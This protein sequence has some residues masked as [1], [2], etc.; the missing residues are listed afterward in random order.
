MSLMRLRREAR[1]HLWTPRRPNPF[2]VT[3]L[4]LLVGMMLTHLVTTLS[5]I[6]RFQQEIVN[7]SFASMDLLLRTG[8]ASVLELPELS[9][10]LLGTFFFIVPWIFIWIVELGYLFYARGIVKGDALGY[11]S[12]MEGFN[13]FFKAVIL[14][15]IRAVLVFI[16]LFSFLIPGI[17]IICALSQASLLLLDHPDKGA[18]WCLRESARIMRGRKMEYFLLMLSFFGWYILTMLPLINIA[19]R[20]WYLPYTTLTY[21]GYYNKITGQ[22]P[23]EPQWRRPG[24]F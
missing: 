15:A 9:P 3:M 24:M 2:L 5:E 21:V 23:E 11:W 22:G 1:A 7:N 10:T 18:L 8:A 13:Y 19:A 14:R 6:G 17:V 4:Y 16:G 20:L 12:L